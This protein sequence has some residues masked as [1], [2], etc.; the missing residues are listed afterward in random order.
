MIR[1]S[2]VALLPALLGCGTESPA[3][4]A[5]TWVHDVAP[6]LRANCFQC[7][8][9]TADYAKFKTVRWDVP[10][11]GHERYQQLGFPPPADPSL[12]LKP[13]VAT[14]DGSHFR[15]MLAYVEPD[16]ADEQRMPPAPATR[17]S[18]RDVQVL[19]NWIEKGDFKLIV[20][21]DPNHP[22]SAG[23][24]QRPA[25]LQVSDDDQDQVLGKLDCGGREIPILRSG[26]LE[27][28]EGVSPPCRATLFDGFDE[29]VVDL[30]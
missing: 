15:L 27:L 10:D 24:L 5:P 1:R 9:P 3:P 28:P 18:A 21:R 13:F 14:N 26:G 6:I 16:V 11:L 8:G 20:R 23:W 22:P 17:L 2:W 12:A 7:H 30:M 25:R 4:E 29:A 19:K